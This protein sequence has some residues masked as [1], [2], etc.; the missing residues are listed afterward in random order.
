M[1]TELILRRRQEQA[2]TAV[3]TP[4]KNITTGEKG[5]NITPLPS[6]IP[7]RKQGVMS[8]WRVNATYWTFMRTQP[9]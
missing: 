8:G 7:R 5:E 4:E 6:F 3:I 9:R 2:T 1:A